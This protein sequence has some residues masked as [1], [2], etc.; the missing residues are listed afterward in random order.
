MYFERHGLVKT[1]IASSVGDS[2]FDSELMR[3]VVKLFFVAGRGPYIELRRG[4]S[5]SRA[6]V[7]V[8]Q[9][10]MGAGGVSV[11][12]LFV[13]HAAGVT[14]GDTKRGGDAASVVLGQDVS[15]GVPREMAVA[16]SQVPFIVKQGVLGLRLI[17][18]GVVDGK[19]G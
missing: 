11:L 17:E 16:F 15:A 19:V 13:D 1:P 12:A 3:S 2:E 4:G 7:V 6:T 10:R 9:V 14:V 18:D 5:A 8:T